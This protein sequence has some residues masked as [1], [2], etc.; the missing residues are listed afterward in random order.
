M[1]RTKTSLLFQRSVLRS[2]LESYISTPFLMPVS[3]SLGVEALHLAILSKATCI[4]IKSICWIHY[5]SLSSY[6]FLHSLDH[7]CSTLACACAGLKPKQIMFFSFHLYADDP[8]IYLPLK[9]DDK[10]AIKPP[11]NCIEKLKLWL[12]DC[13]YLQTLSPY[14]T[15]CIRNLGGLDW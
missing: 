15:T 6:K 3:F 10:S 2:K 4:V 1:W 5:I 7:F 14:S 9:R 11:L 8:Q 13:L 12:A